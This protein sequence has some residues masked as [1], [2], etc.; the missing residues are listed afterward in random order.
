[1]T[2]KKRLH[3]LVDQLA[4]SQRDKAERFLKDLAREGGIT[5]LDPETAAWLKADLSH[6]SDYEPYDWGADG[7]PVGLPPV[8]YVSGR[9]FVIEDP[10]IG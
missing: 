7:P 4:E 1:M 6:L 10:P 5:E 3:Q 2:T 8:R 9:G